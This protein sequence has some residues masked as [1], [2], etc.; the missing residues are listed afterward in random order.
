[1]RT[2][3]WRDSAVSRGL[4]DVEPHVRSWDKATR[5]FLH[6][7]RTLDFG[8]PTVAGTAYPL[9]PSTI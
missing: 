6:R 4:Q 3:I 9:T 2:R 8:L 7:L 5:L 1:M